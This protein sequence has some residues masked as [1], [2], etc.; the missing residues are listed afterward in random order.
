MGGTPTRFEEIRYLFQGL[1]S[2][3][4]RVEH[5]MD[6]FD[7]AFRSGAGATL[8]RETVMAGIY[9]IDLAAC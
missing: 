3:G 9:K 8:E 6:N 1:E 5:M 4:S 7:G 2:S